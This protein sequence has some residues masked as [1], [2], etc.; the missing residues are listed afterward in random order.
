DALAWRLD[1][2]EQLDVMPGGEPDHGRLDRGA[3]QADDAAEIL[4]AHLAGAEDLQ[5]EHVAEECEGSFQVGDGEAGVMGSDDGVHEEA[6]CR[7]GS[8]H[9]PGSER[10]TPGKNVRGLATFGASG[11]A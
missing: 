7:S 10:P 11:A 3:G 6:P 1:V 8:S 2:L 4:V 5:A 9:C